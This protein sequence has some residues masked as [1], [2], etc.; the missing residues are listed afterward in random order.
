SYTS[1]PALLG[2]AMPAP[3]RVAPLLLRSLHAHV[4]ARFSDRRLRQIMGYPA[5]F[6]G[7]SP[8]R[9]PSMYHLMSALDLTGGVRYPLG[10]F[11]E[12]IDA[13]AALAREHGVRI[14]TGC[15]VTAITT[16]PPGPRRGRAGVPGLG[17]RRRRAWSG[18]VRARATGV[19]YRDDTGP[20]R[21]LDAE[22][23]VAA[24]DLHHLEHDLLPPAL[25]DFSA[26][27]WRRHDP[28]PGG[29]LAYLGVQG[30]LPQLRHHT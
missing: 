22:L 25:R 9:T 26:R 11:I 10:G 16:E 2:R 15:T 18:G 17:D 27:W 13:V 23:V 4:A 7:S 30:H 29:V 19:T 14:R 21:T 3:H 8:R 5:V 28:G 1:M 24:T 6:L 20:T 12:L